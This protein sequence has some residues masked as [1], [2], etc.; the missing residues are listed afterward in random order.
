MHS[1]SAAPTIRSRSNALQ[2]PPVSQ[3]APAVTD[4]CVGGRC[5]FCCM[6]DAV[7]RDN[8]MIEQRFCRLGTTAAVQPAAAVVFLHRLGWLLFLLLISTIISA[9]LP[10]SYLIDVGVEEGFNADLPFLR[11]FHTVEA[12]PA[13]VTY[14]WAGAESL[15]VIPQ[16]GGRP[17]IV[18]LSWLE[19]D[20]AL[21][22]AAAATFQ[23]TAQQLTVELP[24]AAEP[25]RQRLLLPVTDTAG[26]VLQISGETVQ[27]PNDV[28]G[29]LLPL[30]RIV[31]QP[32][33]AAAQ[34]DW[35]ALLRWAAAL[36]A[37][38][39]IAVQL[40]PARGA[41][42]AALGLTIAVSAAVLLDGPRW[43]FGADAAA[44]ATLSA[45]AAVPLLRRLYQRLTDAQTADQLVL[46]TAV[47]FVLR[48]AGRLYPMSM[49]GDLGF[50]RNR[51]YEAIGGMISL[52]SLNRGIEFPYPP[53]P[54]LLAAPLVTLGFSVETALQLTAGLA[55]S[56]SVVLVFLIARRV[57]EPRIALLAA[58]LYVGTAATLLT[59]WW[60]FTTHIV[61]QLL[62]LVVILVLLQ[63]WQCWTAAD[64]TPGQRRAWTIG[65]A[66]VTALLMVGHFGYLI[67]ITV[68]F[69]LLT[70]AVWWAAWRG[71][72]AAHRARWP[73]TAAVVL[74]GATAAV[75]F[76]SSYLPLFL[77]QAE[78]VIEGG[79]TAVAG[80]EPASRERL[81]QTLWFAG[82]WQ[83]F[84]L[85]PVPLAIVGLWRLR[86]PAAWLWR[87]ISWLSLTVALLFGSLPFLTLVS[88][89]PRYLMFN[90][91]PIAV[92]SAAALAAL[93][94]H[95]RPARLAAIVMTAVILANSAWFWITPL[96]YRIRP[97]E[98]F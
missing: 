32:T 14:R 51:F 21:R 86:T 20:P 91:L 54:Y 31:V 24:I 41:W 48:L 37:A 55:D 35:A 85:F 11:S 53:A 59:H 2:G 36:A 96:L 71:D 94:R 26:L 78:R 72:A 39:W 43:A 90:L 68:L 81:W 58:A 38:A 3:A 56:A 67:N 18:E 25:R 33:L 66:A 87:R 7:Q 46:L 45:A 22:D 77:A 13:G 95:S 76:Y 64:S 23:L 19:V 75:L 40:L 93:W 74:A 57:V 92:G 49:M 88:N 73:L 65:L 27:P 84:G 12:T 97:P 4:R 52:L 16:L 6:S 8:C 15:I 89:S 80:R 1:A 47:T 30:E 28:R 61:S 44:W 42:T 98:P 70:A 10:R 29:L 17:Q 5:R 34:I 50:H 82:L 9:Q 79:A 69:G 60:S 83:H 62:Y 63:A